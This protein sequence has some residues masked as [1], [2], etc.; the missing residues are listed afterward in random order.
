MNPHHAVCTAERIRVRSFRY[1]R[2]GEYTRF[3]ILQALSFER[4]EEGPWRDV[5]AATPLPD[6]GG[7]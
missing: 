6:S 5:S 3:D 1:A 2:A 7:A 4:R